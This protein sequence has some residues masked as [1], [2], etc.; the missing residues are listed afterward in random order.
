[1]KHLIEKALQEEKA[2]A[3]NGNPSTAVAVLE[4]LLSERWMPEKGE[5]YWFIY[6]IDGVWKWT[7]EGDETDFEIY[8][9][10][11]VYK[12]KEEAEAMLQLLIKVAQGE[13]VVVDKE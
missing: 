7:W 13:A 8:S 5:E 10:L 1:M 4:R 3:A 9:G 11:G 2:R 12:T 6:G